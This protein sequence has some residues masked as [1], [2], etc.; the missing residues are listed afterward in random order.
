M[1]EAVRTTET[2]AYSNETTQRYIR[3]DS[4]LQRKSHVHF[5][6]QTTSPT[7]SLSTVLKLWT[8][9]YKFQNTPW[10]FVWIQVNSYCPQITSD[11]WGV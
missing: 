6:H 7:I 10:H 8:A 2:S 1:M 3:E 4:K 9:L 5:L 11:P